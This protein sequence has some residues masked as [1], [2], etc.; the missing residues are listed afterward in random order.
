MG[1]EGRGTSETEVKLKEGGEVWGWK[2]R[3]GG[4]YERE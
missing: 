3:G 1:R 4:I 2:M